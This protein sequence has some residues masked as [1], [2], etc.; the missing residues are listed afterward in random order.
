MPFFRSQI[1]LGLLF[2][3]S[4]QSVSNNV[5]FQ[6]RPWIYRQQ[7]QWQQNETR[8][9]MRVEDPESWLSHQDKSSVSLVKHRH[10]LFIKWSR[11]ASFMFDETQYSTQF[12]LH[13]WRLCESRQMRS[14]KPTCNLKSRGNWARVARWVVVASNR[15]SVIRYKT[16]EILGDYF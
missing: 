14:L 11:I 2:Y 5:L 8:Q 10:I 13:L 3:P 4:S 15:T 16:T 7:W 9:L 12:L 6:R 1:P